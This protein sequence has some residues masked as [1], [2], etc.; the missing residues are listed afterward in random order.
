MVVNGSRQKRSRCTRVRAS[1]YHQGE[2]DQRPDDTEDPDFDG[3]I[4][5]A[6][7]RREPMQELH[8]LPK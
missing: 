3:L 2:R 1:G 6:A 5:G 7:F 4:R 8:A